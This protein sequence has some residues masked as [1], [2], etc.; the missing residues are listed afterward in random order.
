MSKKRLSILSLLLVL[1]LVLTACG[2]NKGKE[3]TKEPEKT[4][5]TGKEE[6]GKEEEGE[7]EEA[8][9]GITI[10]LPYPNFIKKEGDVVGGT[11]NVGIIASSPFEGVFNSFLYEIQTDSEIMQ[12]MWNGFMKGGENSELGPGGLCDVEFD[13]NAKTATYIIQDG[14]TW[15]DGVPVTADDLIY[16]YEMIAH[17]DYTG[18]RYDTDYMNVV[19]IEE[20]HAGEADTISGLKK[21]DDQRLEVTFKEFYPGI[22]WG[23]GITYNI[24]PKHYL[25]HIAPEDLKAAPEIREKPLSC[26]PFVM[27]NIVPGESVEYIPN[28][29]WNGDKPLVDKIIMKVVN[30]DNAVEAMKAGEVD[31][32]M[33]MGVNS[34]DQYK[35][36]NNIELL[37]YVSRSYNYIGFKLGT[38]D[39]EAGKVVVDDT[40]KMS[41]V[42][43][44]QAMGYAIDSEQIS[45]VFYNNLRF[46]ANSLI[47][48]YHSFWNNKQ[49]GYHYDPDRAMEILDEAGYVDVDG[50]GFRETPDGEKLTINYIARAGGET[51]EPLNQFYIQ[52]WNDIG[53]DV[54]LK[55][56]RLIEVNAFY[57]MVQEDAEGIDV[58]EAG[59]SVGSN[60][61]PSGL[62]GRD[63]QFNFPRFAT[64]ANDAVLAK[65]ASEDIFD[66]NGELDNE[67]LNEAY[68]E[69]QALMVEEAPVIPTTYGIGID[70]LNKRVNYYDERRGEA[71][72]F[73][74]E[75]IGLLSDKP[76]VHQ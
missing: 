50:D 66:E 16:V 55:D 51:A 48:P 73:G 8:A 10:D 58:F 31:L 64:E 62:Y 18:V 72:E 74:W 4:E 14:L 54:V 75:K 71:N 5:E 38:Y 63:A 7:K 65:I 70:V 33:N 15:S 23:A 40:L 61:D 22:L 13:A 20:Y 76:E 32:I 19:G 46:P 42:K 28:E 11:L 25:E 68:H 1:V 41:D 52:N 53:L 35:D 21:L 39:K 3:E 59:W 60:P 24:E 69:W 26:G 56:G 29:H 6:T 45:E 27:N 12:P 9:E 36:L 2:G 17:K 67:F 49:E 43:L 47:T 30:P 57:D 44:R 37:S 34:Y